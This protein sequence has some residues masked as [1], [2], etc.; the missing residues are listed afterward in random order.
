MCQLYIFFFKK[1]ST[2]VYPKHCRFSFLPQY[3]C[4]YTNYSIHTNESKIEKVVKYT[5]F[6][7]KIAHFNGCIDA[8]VYNLSIVTMHISTIIVH[9]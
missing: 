4:K 2:L 1:L 3:L 8:Q 6:G 7:P 9:V 5:H